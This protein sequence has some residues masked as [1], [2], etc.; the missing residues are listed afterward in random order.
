MA[1]DIIDNLHCE[2]CKEKIE[3]GWELQ[4]LAPDEWR[5]ACEPCINVLELNEGK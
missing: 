4:E 2:L 1:I 5:V 3:G